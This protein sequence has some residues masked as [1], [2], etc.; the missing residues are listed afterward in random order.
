MD[1]CHLSVLQLPWEKEDSLTFL[2]PTSNTKEGL[3]RAEAWIGAR[4]QFQTE[5][6]GSENT[7]RWLTHKPCLSTQEKRCLQRTNASRAD[8]RA[9]AKAAVTD[10]LDHSPPKSSPP[11]RRSRIPLVSAPNP[12]ALV[13]LHSLLHKQKLS[14]VN[15][16]R[17]A[18]VGGRKMKRADFIK[19]IKETKVPI[20]DKDLEDV[21]IFLTS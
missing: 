5:R 18:G 4:G 1:F 3:Q 16:F 7:E 19:V 20:S 12:Q 13:T 9:A 14:L 10:S 21:V 2:E 15:V 8:G 17:K 11:R 6:E